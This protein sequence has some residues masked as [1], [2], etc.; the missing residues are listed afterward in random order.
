MAEE[1]IAF[2]VLGDNYMG[3]SSGFGFWLAGKVIVFWV[4]G[5]NYIGRSG[6]FEF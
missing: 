5:D 6:G 2:S 1:G 4:S 3:K